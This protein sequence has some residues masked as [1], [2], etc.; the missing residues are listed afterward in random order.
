[1]GDPA[2]ATSDAS[3]GT[4][5]PADPSEDELA[6]H[7]SLTPTD[8]VVIAECRGPDHRRRFALQLCMLRN[9]GRFLEDYRDAPI[10]IVNHLSRQLDLAPV[11]VSRSA[12]PGTDG[13]GTIAAYPSSSPNPGF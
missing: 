9:Q 11:S 8:L 1:M 2:T 12:R 3:R 4:S 10:K 6:R 5:L 7:W 13:A